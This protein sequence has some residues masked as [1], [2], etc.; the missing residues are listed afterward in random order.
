[1]VRC[2]GHERPEIT[3]LEGIEVLRVAHVDAIHAEG[4]ILKNG[5]SVHEAEDVPAIGRANVPRRGI[6]HRVC[7]GKGENHRNHVSRDGG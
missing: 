4:G 3:P 1:M 6:E 7:V 2:S 5:R